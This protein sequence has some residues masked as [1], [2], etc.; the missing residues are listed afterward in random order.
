M[1]PLIHHLEVSKQGFV[2][3]VLV[4]IWK[5]RHKNIHVYSNKHYADWDS[6]KG[7]L[8]KLELK[9]LLGQTHSFRETF[10]FNDIIIDDVTIIF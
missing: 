10:R 1:G 7:V 2:L 5:Y 4:T 9:C 6:C 8:H 3:D